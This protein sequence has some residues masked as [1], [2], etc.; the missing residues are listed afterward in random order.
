MPL[1]PTQS[2]VSARDCIA[3]WQASTRAASAVTAFD[4][5][6]ALSMRVQSAVKSATV[7]FPSQ[8]SDAFFTP[9]ARIASQYFSA[10]G[11]GV[12]PDAG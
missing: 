6:A 8:H 4:A 1:G 11:S 7:L 3:L 5:S 12:T 2:Q 9:S 10:N